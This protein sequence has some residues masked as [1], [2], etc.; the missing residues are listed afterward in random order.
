MTDHLPECPL[1]HIDYWKF[2][3]R[4]CICPYLRSCEQ[5]VSSE[6]LTPMDL[7]FT[8]MSDP[9]YAKDFIAALDAARGV[10]EKQKYIPLENTGQFI[11]TRNTKLWDDRKSWYKHGWWQF[12]TSALAAIDALREER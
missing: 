2:S 9:R 1:S 3:L 5:R 8:G 7:A 11:I 6:F 4:E 12:R 10:V